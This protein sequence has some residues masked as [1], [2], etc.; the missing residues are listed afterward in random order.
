MAARKA[1]NPVKQ[2]SVLNRLIN[3]GMAEQEIKSDIQLA[4][5]LG[6]SHASLSKRRTGTTKWSWIEVCR[7]ARVLEFSPDAVLQAMGAA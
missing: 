5:L 2:L 1:L 4:A 7:L 6:M 3:I